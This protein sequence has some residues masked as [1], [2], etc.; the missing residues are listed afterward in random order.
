MTFGSELIKRST[1]EVIV[2][3]I[4]ATIALSVLFSG[5]AVAILEIVRPES[6]TT[7]VVSIL[8]DVINTLIG[9]MAGFL[10]GR[11]EGANPISQEVTSSARETNV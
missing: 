1:G 10:A 11:T 8:S 9:V 3:M 7:Q 5:M 6:D 2:L 4:A